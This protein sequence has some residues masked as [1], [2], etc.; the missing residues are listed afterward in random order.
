[1][2]LVYVVLLVFSSWAIFFGNAHPLKSVG[3]GGLRAKRVA[4]KMCKPGLWCLDG[5][6]EV[7]GQDFLSQ[8]PLI[9]EK[10]S[11]EPMKEPHIPE[12]KLLVTDERPKIPEKSPSTP[13]YDPLSLE[14]NRRAAADG[15]RS[16]FHIC[17]RAIGRDDVDHS[18]RRIQRSLRAKMLINCVKFP[19]LCE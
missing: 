17:K 19:F 8:K 7:S 12:R 9:P 2:N 6:R 13:K 1:M 18:L 10:V 15:Y 11:Y 3:T 4:S 16:S 14:Q 5:K